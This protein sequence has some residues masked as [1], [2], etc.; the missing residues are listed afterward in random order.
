MFAPCS[1]SRRY[2]YIMSTLYFGAKMPGMRCKRLKVVE[3]VWIF[4]IFMVVMV[5]PFALT[6]RVLYISRFYQVVNRVALDLAVDSS[7]SLSDN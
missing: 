5:M 4:G 1:I 7:R 6:L 2:P 3:C